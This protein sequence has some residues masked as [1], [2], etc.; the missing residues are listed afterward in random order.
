MVEWKEIG[1]SSTLYY[2]P[3]SMEEVWWQRTGHSFHGMITIRSHVSTNHC[4]GSVQYRKRPCCYFR[5]FCGNI[6]AIKQILLTVVKQGR[7]RS[8]RGSVA[9]IGSC[10][11]VVMNLFNYESAFPSILKHQ[12][13]LC[14]RILAKH[15]STRVRTINNYN[16]QQYK[17]TEFWLK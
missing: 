16:P 2:V 12:C 9:S 10:K 14:Q 13:S 4:L 6:T 15:I 17:N 11:K 7:F 8:T 5:S 3:F 1:N